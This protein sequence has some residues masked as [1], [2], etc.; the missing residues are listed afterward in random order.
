MT[1]IWLAVSFWGTE[2]M[3][4]DRPIREEDDPQSEFWLPPYSTSRE[5]N[6][7]EGTIERI[8][9]MYL[10]WADEAVMVDERSFK[11]QKEVDRVIKSHP[12]VWQ[13]LAED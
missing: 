5:T 3:F 6:L 2:S 9:G 13:Q 4:T 7:P 12:E 10:T 11:I 1:Q 8:L